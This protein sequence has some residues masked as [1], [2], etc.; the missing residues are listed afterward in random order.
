MPPWDWPGFRGRP[1]G[2]TGLPLARSTH[3]ALERLELCRNKCILPTN[4]LRV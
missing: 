2:R 4:Q 3:D 1:S